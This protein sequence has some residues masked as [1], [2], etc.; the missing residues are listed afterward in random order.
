MVSKNRGR[1][2][3]QNMKRL[4]AAI[5]DNHNGIA[6][7]SGSYIQCLGIYLQ[8][9]EAKLKAI[10]SEHIRCLPSKGKMNFAK[11]LQHW[12]KS[13][14]KDFSQSKAAKFLGVSVRTLQEWEQGRKVPR[15]F[16][17]TAVLD[18]IKQKKSSSFV[19][20][21]PRLVLKEGVC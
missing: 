3:T 20:L 2:Q 5:T 16:T 15:E 14:G 10:V 4:S 8:P 1:A 12:R 19:R 7:G 9:W 13:M 6:A 21:K 18:K 11:K 17:I